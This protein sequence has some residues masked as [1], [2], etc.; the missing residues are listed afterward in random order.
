MKPKQKTFII[1]AVQQHKSLV[2]L[3]I[4]QFEKNKHSLFILKRLRLTYKSFK[5]LLTNL[6]V[7]LLTDD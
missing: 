4:R 3:P 6:F 1:E 5:Y 7:M 2:S